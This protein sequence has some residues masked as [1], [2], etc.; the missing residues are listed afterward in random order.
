MSFESRQNPHLGSRREFLKAAAIGTGAMLLARGAVP[1]A[2]HEARGVIDVNVSLGQ[3]PVRRLPLNEPDQLV[4]KLRSRGVTQAWT[5]SLEGLLHKDIGAVNERLAEDC[6]RHG[7]GLLLPFGSI[8]PCGPGWEQALDKCAQIHRFKGIRLHP[9]YHGYG[10]DHPAF[11]RL[12]RLAAERHLIVQLAIVMED[13][14]MM[15]PLLRVQPVETAPL[16]E[17]VRQTPGLRLV[18]LNALERCAANS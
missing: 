3:W 2:A 17:L 7:H 10:L 8:N 16:S 14:R 5:G 1:A 6:R 13:E 12:L 4:A 11:A 9:N 18:L 15:H